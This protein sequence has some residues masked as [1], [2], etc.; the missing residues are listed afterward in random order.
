MNTTVRLVERNSLPMEIAT[1]STAHTNATS[2]P[3]SELPYADNGR[4]V[5]P[6]DALSVGNAFC[7]DHA[8]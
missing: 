8:S 3:G 4:R 5:Q 7:Q 2:P 1:G 6:G